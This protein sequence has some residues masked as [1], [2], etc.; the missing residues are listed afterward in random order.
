[1][2]ATKISARPLYRV[3]TFQQWIE[4]NGL[5]DRTGRRILKSGTGPKVTW[6]SERRFG[7]REDHDLAWLERCAR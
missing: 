1:M 3:L 2:P 4:K 6:I 5:S 7:I